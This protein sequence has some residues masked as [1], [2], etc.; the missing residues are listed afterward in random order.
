M[1]TLALTAAPRSLP[2]HHEVTARRAS[3]PHPEASAQ[4][5]SVPH[6]EVPAQRASKDLLLERHFLA[7][8]WPARLRSRAVE[9]AV[10]APIVFGVAYA[11][12]AGL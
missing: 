7:L 11:L 8:A 4:R 6:P 2:P 3:A 10:L 9:F 12:A 5:A 1:A